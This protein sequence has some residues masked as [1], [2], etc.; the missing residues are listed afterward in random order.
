MVVLYPEQIQRLEEDFIQIAFDLFRKGR[1]SASGKVCNL[2][3]KAWFGCSLTVIAKVWNLLE[4]LGGLHELATKDRLLW[5]LYL[6]KQY[7][8]D[9]TCAAACGGVDEATFRRW[10]WYFVE[11]ISYLESFT[12]SQTTCIARSMSQ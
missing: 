3:V 11:E 8:N 1:R 6:L 12:V 7:A 10:A 9:E 2:R 4:R 5:G